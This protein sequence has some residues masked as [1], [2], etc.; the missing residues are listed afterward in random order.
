MQLRGCI[1]LSVHVQPRVTEGNSP[2]FPQEGSAS[3]G[4]ACI[5]AYPQGGRDTGAREAAKPKPALPAGRPRPGPSF[6]PI[7][8]C[9]VRQRRILRHREDLFLGLDGNTGT[10]THGGIV[11]DTV[12]SRKG[13]SRFLLWRQDRRRS[14]TAARTSLLPTLR[15]AGPAV[16]RQ[17]V[18]G[19]SQSGV[20][21]S[22]R[23]L[24]TDHGG[25]RMSIVVFV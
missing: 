18:T 15:L 14:R 3:A 23:R 24:F 7:R 11:P 10:R 1:L 20:A 17:P 16:W 6:H 4:W 12:V 9:P 21:Q 22:K 25:S 2:S 8:G 13:E 5:S 19:A